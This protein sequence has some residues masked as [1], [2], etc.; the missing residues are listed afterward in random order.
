MNPFVINPKINY[1]LLHGKHSLQIGYEYLYISTV[2]SNTHPQFGTDT[3]KGLFTTSGTAPKLPSGVADPA[4]KEAWA[5]ADFAFGARSEYE[6]SN[7]TSVTDN[8]RYH[9]AYAQDDWRVLP[10]LTLNLGLRYEFATPVWESNNELSNFNPSTQALVQASPGSLYNR[11]LVEPNHLNFAPRLGVAYSID[12]KTVI[13]AAYGIGY[14][15]FN[16]VAGADELASNLPTSVDIPILQNPADAKS[17]PL[18]LCTG[19]TPLPASDLGTCFVST[20]QGY[21]TGMLAAPTQPYN[22]LQNTPTY[23]PSHTPTTYVQSFLLNVQR[24]LARNWTL[25][26]GYVGNV[27]V[28]EL[29]LADANQS[30]AQ[31]LSATCN[32][33]TGV[34]T[35]CL[36]V[37]ARRPF[38]TTYCCADISEAFNEGHSNY[39]SLQVKLEKRYSQGLYLVNAF[40]WSHSMDDA[41]GHL[42][43]EDGDSE[44]VN[45]YNLAADRG[46]AGEDQPINET[47]ALTYDLPYGKG[48]RFGTSAPYL[49]QLLAGGWQTSILN[50]YTSGLPVNLTYTQSGTYLTEAAVDSSLLAAYFRANVSGNPVLPLGQQAKTSAYRLYLNSANVSAP[51]AYNMPFGNA[52]RNSVRAPNYDTLDMSIHKRF[53]LWSA[54]SALELRVDA[55]NILNHV[56]YQAPDGNITDTTFGEITTAYP[57]RELQGALKLFF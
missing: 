17:T 19:T 50:Q 55:F 51:T 53:P 26:V 24:Q 54:E 46:R 16:R 57:A 21:P 5:L 37:Q 42:E 31:V 12:P 10:N 49:L 15:Q 48:R 35:G 32:A 39:N 14:V 18:P 36:S 44:Y 11:A 3:Y 34:V 47:L 40:T 9:A 56:N 28:H 22:L 43:E 38:N 20:Q 4:Y 13:H 7:N 6:L 52:A 25:S 33:T 1:S 23:V 2:I 30:S 41:A 8:T 45:I 29:L 27:G